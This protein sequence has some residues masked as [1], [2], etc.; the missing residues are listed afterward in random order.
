MFKRLAKFSI[1]LALAALIWLIVGAVSGEKMQPYRLII[2]LGVLFFYVVIQKRV[3]HS[4]DQDI[5]PSI[6]RQNKEHKSWV[7]RIDR[8]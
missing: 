6:R 4:P 8:D 1:F 3:R 7:N 5:A 2:L